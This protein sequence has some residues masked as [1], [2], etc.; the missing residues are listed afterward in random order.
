MAVVIARQGP[1]VGET[2][3]IANSKL[4]ARHLRGRLLCLHPVDSPA[5]DG[6]VSHNDLGPL[7]QSKA[8]ND[9]EDRPQYL[10]GKAGDASWDS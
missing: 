4:R 3:G 1:V 9:K 5:A 8:L 7:D 2:W 6:C 10:M